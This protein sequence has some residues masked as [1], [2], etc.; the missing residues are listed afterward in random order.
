MGRYPPVPDVELGGRRAGSRGARQDGPGEVPPDP[1]PV[2][3]LISRPNLRIGVVGLVLGSVPATAVTLY[4]ELWLVAVLTA[5][6]IAGVVLLALERRPR[7]PWCARCGAAADDGDG[8]GLC[9]LCATVRRQQEA[10]RD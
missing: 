7:T 1:P 10:D 4:A 8:T 6:S 9:E 3:P 2:R 5:V